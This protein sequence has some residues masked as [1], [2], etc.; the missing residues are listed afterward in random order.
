MIRRFLSLLILA[1]AVP[2]QAQAA[3]FAVITAPPT[4]LSVIILIAAAVALFFCSQVWS[5]VKG[6]QLSRIW[7]L[8]MIGLLLLVI[9]R[10]LSL[11]NDFQIAMMPEFLAPAVMAMMAGA[12]V[13]GMMEAKRVF[14]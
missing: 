2:A 10:A 3:N 11:L 12:F 13:Y 6:G 8:F 14:G 5:S 9:N 7:Q 1:A 4:A